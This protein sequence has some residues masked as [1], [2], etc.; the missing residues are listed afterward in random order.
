MRYELKNGYISKVF[1]GCHSGTCTLYEGTIPAGYSSLE[2]W[3]NKAN[4]RAY[5]I[6]SG[7][8]TYDSAKD[9]EL[10]AVY[11][12]EEAENNLIRY[13]DVSLV[14]ITISGLPS[15]SGYE[16]YY[17]PALKMVW[18][19]IYLTGKS[20]TA[21]TRHTI[22]TIPS[23]YR[24]TRRTALATDSLQDYTYVLRAH[25]TSDGTIAF[26]SEMAKEDTDD[27]YISGSWVVSD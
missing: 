11:E 12:T 17:I 7:N 19:S 5:K 10:Q 25:V 26:I 6:V 8:L 4:I 21:S 3:A 16:C 23:G 13:K 1:F 27:M 2:E 24:P 20:Y 9:T 15:G 14:P 22:G 18:C